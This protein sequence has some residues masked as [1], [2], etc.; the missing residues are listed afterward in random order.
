MGLSILP[1]SIAP[2]ALPAPTMVCISSM[3]R[4]ILPSALLTSVRTALSRSSNSPRN[5]APARREPISRVKMVL[6]LRPSGTSPRTIRWARPSTIAVFPTPGSPMR[7]G[8]F[9]VFRERIRITRRISASRPMTGSSLP[10]LACSTRSMPYFLSARK[11]FSGVLEVTF[12]PPL[13]FC[14]VSLIFFSESSKFFKNCLKVAGLP[15]AANP[16]SRCSVLI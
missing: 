1:A 16:S 13:M 7:T 15:T 6:S 3:K 4:T 14:R 9:L 2:S 5:F 11:E 10:D 8:L 12:C